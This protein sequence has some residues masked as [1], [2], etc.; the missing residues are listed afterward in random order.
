MLKEE[1][2]N[3]ARTRRVVSHDEDCSG[4]WLVA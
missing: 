3:S 2:R 1:R 4:F